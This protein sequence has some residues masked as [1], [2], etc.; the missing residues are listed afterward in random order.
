MKNWLFR[1]LQPLIEAA[2]T[3]RIVMFHDALVERHQIKAI[4]TGHCTAVGVA[5]QDQLLQ[6]SSPP[7]RQELCGHVRA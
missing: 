6:P 1:K 5:A 7:R 3:Q 2:I 4:S